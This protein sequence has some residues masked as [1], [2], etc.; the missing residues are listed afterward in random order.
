MR[1]ALDSD[2]LLSRRRRVPAPPG[3]LLGVPGLL[4]LWIAGGRAL[5]AALAPLTPRAQGLVTIFLGIF[6]EA[7]PFVLAGVLVSSAIAIY[8]SDSVIQRLAPRGRFGAAFAGSAL[9]LLFPVCECGTVP[10]TRRLLHKGAPLPFGVAFLLAAPVVNPVVI[11]STYV[12]FSGDWLM[13]GS[14][15]G[16]TILIAVTTALVLSWLPRQSTLLAPSLARST[17]G[18]G[19][20]HES[21]GRSL[22][23]ALSH[24]ADE[25]IEMSR[26]LILGALLAATL[27]TFVP[28]SVLLSIGGGPVISVVLL[29]AL[30]TLLSV[31]STVDAFLALALSSTFGPGALLAFLVFGPMIDIKSGMMFLTTLSPRAVT[32]IVALVTPLVLT[33]GVLVN[34]VWR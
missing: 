21:H 26:W 15:V 28:Q 3:W 25:L 16:L 18:C 11:V 32:I 30:A 17:G 29:M 9:G 22:I 19:C 1:I 34:L 10:T 7:L 5:P 6:I 13:V 2:T 4:L 27:Q 20:E 8:V 23:G 24:S 14:R 31:C 33:A 12:A